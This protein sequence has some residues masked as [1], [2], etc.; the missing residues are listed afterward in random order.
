MNFD[1]QL[2]VLDNKLTRWHLDHLNDYATNSKYT[3]SQLSDTNAIDRDCRF[4]SHLSESEMKEIKIDLILQPVFSK[5]MHCCL[6]ANNLDKFELQISRP[7]DQI[8]IQLWK[9]TRYFQ[10]II[11]I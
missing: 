11:Y 8:Y 9:Q 1:N 5:T 10:R 3:Y 6:T 4:V 7:S 2:L